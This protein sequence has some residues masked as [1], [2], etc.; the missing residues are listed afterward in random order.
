VVVVTNSEIADIF[1]EVADI[2][3]I[4]GAN[5]FRV[6]AYRTAARTV[7][8]LGRNVA[9]MINAGEDLTELQGIGEDLAGKIEEIVETGSL[10]QLEH[11]KNETSPELAKLLEIE[12]LGPK[13]VRQ[14]HEALGVNTL[15]ELEEAAE[16]DKI[17]RLEGFGSVLQEKILASVKG[18]QGQEERIQL[19]T[20]EDLAMPLVAYL[21]SLEA[22]QRIEVAGSYRRR[23]ETVGDLDILTISDDWE[24]V[25]H[26]F[27]NYDAVV[28]IVSQGKTR[29][30]VILRTGLQVDLRVVSPES[31]GA[32]LF[33]FTGSKA[34]NI[35]IRNLAIDR[36]MK[37]N[38]YGVF[39]GDRRIAGE[40]EEEIYGLFD[41]PFTPPELREDR[42][43][44]EAARKGELPDLVTVE[45]IRGDLQMHTDASDGRATL[46][47][48]VRAAQKRGY[49]YIAITDHSPHVVVTQGLD[50]D[51]LAKQ[52]DEI[53]AMNDQ[54]DD[55]RILKSIE[56][57]ILADGSLDLPN[58][59]LSRL[60][61]TLCSIHSSF[62]LSREKQ[63]ERI[64]RAMDNPNFNILAHPTGRRIGDRA[65]IDVDL[66][67]VMEAALER[68]CF[69]EVNAQPDRLDLNDIYS[70]MAKEM[71]LKL[72]ISTDA[73]SPDELAFMAYGVYQ[74]RR[75]WL[76]ADDI[77]NTQGWKELQTLLARD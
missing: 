32:A 64:I 33:Y 15:K 17:E 6:R 76:E 41:L 45:D 67:R 11:L 16:A 19:R 21:R 23:Q 34:H 24:E 44:I 51:A 50:A 31:H 4:Q 68:N 7:S 73:H 77:L 22:V 54:L 55:I 40:T 39:E 66:E 74:A 13:R 5:P 12:E 56:V 63:T 58:S 25:S 2:L 57:D 46:E 71:G 72:S 48:M 35:A 59:I 62:G 70:K 53:D 43:E 8:A 30:T 38:E 27:I 52:I 36:G 20:A 28:D 60:D 14:L 1:R 3:E 69:L 10:E 37:V 47:E 49:E 75:G 42:G 29:S 61:L 65:P 9:D 18:K 26:Q